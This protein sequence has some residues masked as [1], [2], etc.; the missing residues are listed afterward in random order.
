MITLSRLTILVAVT[1]TI[2]TIAAAAATT[3]IYTKDTST[4]EQEIQQLINDIIDD[5]ASYIQV[6]DI[7][8]KYHDHKGTQKITQ[9]ALLIKPL[10]TE[11]IDVSQLMLQLSNGESLQLF[12]YGES[13]D[14]YR[15]S[16]LFEHTLWTTLSNQTFGTLVTLDKDNS[17]VQHHTFNKN[18]DMAFLIINLPEEYYLKKG[19]T[20]TI[21]LLPTQGMQRT[22]ELEAPLPIQRVVTLL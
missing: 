12:F 16:H 14:R 8:G 11:Q 13:V 10:T 5:V 20:L 4:D 7:I 22:F 17:L 21:K 19:D 18:T 2:F 15:S 9:I 1:L 6:K 3:V